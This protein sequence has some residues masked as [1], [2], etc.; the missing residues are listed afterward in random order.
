MHR[1]IS[2]SGGLILVW[3]IRLIIWVASNLLLNFGLLLFFSWPKKF[4][5]HPSK[6][7]FQLK[8][9]LIYGLVRRRVGI[10]HKTGFTRRGGHRLPC[11]VTITWWSSP[12]N[13]WTPTAKLTIWPSV[14]FYRWPFNSGDSSV[15][16]T[17]PFEG[18]QNDQR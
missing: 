4:G 14:T 8:S 18:K 10:P 17:N 12:P 9:R 13:E 6:W 16:V 15:L 5:P 2:G 11:G 1:R 7:D 3:P